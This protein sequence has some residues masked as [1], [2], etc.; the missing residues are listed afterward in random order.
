[1]YAPLMNWRLLVA[2]LASRA[3]SGDIVI[4]NPPHTSLPFRYYFRKAGRDGRRRPRVA[5]LEAPVAGRPFIP[6]RRLLGR[7]VWLVE[8]ASN[9]AIP[10][11]KVAQ[12]L[13]AGGIGYHEHHDGLVGTIRVILCNTRRAAE[14]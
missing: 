11:E 10:N 1:M 8:A 14:P 7:R 2:N 9:I 6:T 4:C 3:K 13:A 12:V 5:L